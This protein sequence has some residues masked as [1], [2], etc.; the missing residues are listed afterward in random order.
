[1]KRTQLALLLAGLASLCGSVHAAEMPEYELGVLLGGG[2]VDDRLVGGKDGEANPLLGLRYSQRLNRD[3]RFFGDLVHGA[4]DGDRAGVGDAE[5]A[6]LRGGVEWLFSRQRQYDWFLA[7]GVGLVHADSDGGVDFTRPAASLGLGQSW[8]VGSNDALR[9]EL[10]ADRS[11]GND[12]LP[13]AGLSSFYALVGYAWGLGEPLDSDGDGVIDRIEQ[14][15]GTPQAATVDDRGCPSDSDHDG[16][17]DG[18]DR[19]P[20]T[21]M[22]AAVDSG[23][24]PLDGDG[25][26]VPDAR[27]KCPTEPAPGSADGCLSRTAPPAAPPPVAPS[28][29][30]PRAPQPPVSVAPRRLTLD[31]VNFE[32][33]SV[34]L[35]ADSI[36]VLDNAAATLQQ[37]GEVRI[38]V[39]GHTDARGSAAYNLELSQRRADAVRAYLVKKGVNARRLTARGYGESDPVADNRT[40][41]GRLQNRRVELVPRQ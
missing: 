8:A 16:V 15:P 11:F 37:W 35:T 31:G 12:P 18:V 5:L 24:C 22:G 39:A 14:C 29:A 9:W 6:A 26:G 19:C 25:D 17:F 41:A 1:M 38:E 21:A 23:G 13:G 10:R 36:A 27:D 2:W 28:A 4:Y 3:F 20:D 30:E 34:R 32:P 33:D 7:G 40:P